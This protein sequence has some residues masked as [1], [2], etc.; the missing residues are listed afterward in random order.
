[1][2]EALNNA[3]K[4][5]KMAL[6]ASC[7]F[8]VGEDEGNPEIRLCGAGNPFEMVS[9]LQAGNPRPLSILWMRWVQG[10]KVSEMVVRKAVEAFEAEG[11]R[12]RGNWC[13][14]PLADASAKMAAL[15]ASVNGQSWTHEAMLEK[16]NEID[17]SR[18]DRFLRS[19]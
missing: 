4:R 3:Q 2:F 1:M 12:H 17:S 5:A 13:V 10:G 14:V 7:V 9:T 18:A 8:I 11:C 15:I 6:G 16:L 19:V